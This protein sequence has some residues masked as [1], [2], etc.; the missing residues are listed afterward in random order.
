MENGKGMREAG[1]MRRGVRASLIS[2]FVLRL[3]SFLCCLPGRWSFCSSSGRIWTVGLSL[4]LRPWPS[5]GS[6]VSWISHGKERREGQTRRQ[7]DK[8][9]KGQGGMEPVH[10]SPSLWVSLSPCLFL[11]RYACSIPFSP[12]LLRRSFTMRSLPSSD[13]SACL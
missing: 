11:G 3:S 9:T 1:R 13:G 4:A 12:F 5:F 6:V 8:E 10:Y 7:G 2:H